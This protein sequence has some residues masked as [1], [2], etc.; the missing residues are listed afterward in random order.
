MYCHV[1]RQTSRHLPAIRCY[2]ATRFCVSAVVA[3][4]VLPTR[5][6]A[7]R[8]GTTRALSCTTCKGTLLSVPLSSPLT[9]LD[10]AFAAAITMCTSRP[11]TWP[12]APWLA[13][14]TWA[15]CSW[16]TC[17]S[18]TKQVL[19]RSSELA[20]D[21]T[22]CRSGLIVGVTMSDADG[23]QIVTV[24]PTDC[25][26]TP[27]AKFPA[28]CT[29]CSVHRVGLMAFAGA[30]CCCVQTYSLLGDASAIDV[31]GRQ[32]FTMV[33]DEQVSR[34]ASPVSC[35]A[36]LLDQAV[37]CMFCC[38]RVW[39]THTDCTWH[40]MVCRTGTRCWWC[41]WTRTTPPRSL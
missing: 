21:R 5:V 27:I 13:A 22:G 28:V 6:R 2:H 37:S 4:F 39:W 16:T 38:A 10:Y 11:S 1:R 23:N 24:D 34:C 29:W 25:Q 19:A 31:A 20:S 14:A 26:L 7:L 32:Y 18:T 33:G 35:S 40:D 17:A 8:V 3:P 30:A 12:M 41:S 15:R 36:C 9:V